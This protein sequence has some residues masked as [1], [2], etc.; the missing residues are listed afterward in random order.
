MW[1]RKKGLYL[2]VRRLRLRQKE[3]SAFFSG[4]SLE[5]GACSPSFGGS[6]SEAVCS[7][8]AEKAGSCYRFDSTEHVSF[9]GNSVTGCQEEEWRT[10]KRDVSLGPLDL[11]GSGSLI[12]FLR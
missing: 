9:R 8:R 4:Q 7:S 10:L 12:R 5:C 2:S 6:F 1:Q 3:A 11:E